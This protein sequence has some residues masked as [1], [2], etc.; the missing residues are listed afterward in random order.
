MAAESGLKARLIMAQPFGFHFPG[1][2]MNLRDSPTVIVASVISWRTFD[3]SPRLD[4]DLRLPYHLIP[5][6]SPEREGSAL[7]KIF[8]IIIKILQLIA[9]A[10]IALPSPSRRGVGGE[11]SP[12]SL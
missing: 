8:T 3:S 5:D 10:L 6:P 12:T 7:N 9:N 11:V 1:E 2:G 4:D